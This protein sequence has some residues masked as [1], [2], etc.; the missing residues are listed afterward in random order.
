[1][2]QYLTFLI[3]FVFIGTV[4]AQ[5]SLDV[6]H[7]NKKRLT[8][9]VLSGTGFY[10][11]SMSLIYLAWYKSYP[12]TRFHIDNDA[13]E[14][15]LKDKLGHLTSSYE[16][17][18][19]SYWALRWVGLNEKRAIWYGGITG[20]VYMTSIEFF[21]GLSSKW[22]A[23]PTDLAANT[24]GSAMFI[25]QQLFWHEQRIRPKFSYHPTSYAQYNPAVLGS[26]NLQRLLKDYNGQTNWFSIN[27]NSFLKKNSR[28][29]KWLDVSVGYGARG[30]IH[31]YS[32]P[33]TINGRKVP[34]FA[35]IPRFFLSADVDWTRI[36]TNSK[37]LR[38]VFKLLSFVK[39]P[40]PALEFNKED[41]FVFH[42][43]YF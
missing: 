10:A 20:L 1:M 36:Q 3:I 8:A 23:S 17:G 25:S 32:N 27:I 14:W 35:R 33:D 18:N 4:S 26:D 13:G 28:F 31:G 6:N 12:E 24:V 34:H 7:I 21:D 15:L 19:Y 41:K 29:P 2:R 39:I 30:M 43:L 5:D 11:T 37:A 40:A 22:G 38:F 16:L 42:P 9:V